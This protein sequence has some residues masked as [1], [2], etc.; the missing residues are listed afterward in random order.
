MPYTITMLFVLTVFCFSAFGQDELKAPISNLTNHQIDSIL[1]ENSSRNLTVTERMKL[2]SEMFLGMGYNFTCI[3]DGENALLEDYPLVNFNQTNCMSYCEHVLALSISDSWD[4][5]FNNLQ[6]IRYS[7]GFIGMRTR[8]HYTMADW[9]PENSWLLDD[10]SANVGGGYTRSV[11]RTISHQEFFKGK[12]ITDLRHVKPDMEVTV[13]YVP[14]EN[15]PQVH[16]NIRSGDVMAILYRDKNDIFSAHMMMAFRIGGDL[17]IRESTTLG[18]T[19]FD[20]PFSDWISSRNGKNRY[21]GIS[22]MRV[23]EG[24]DLPGRVI[25]PWEIQA[26]KESR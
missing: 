19:T 5:F 15:L 2:Y 18:M 25:L 16:K 10:V 17:V 13:D 7:G 4:N 9:L 20:T 24:L 21:I 1:T 26:L 11:T 8:N 6:Q 12:G 3:G 23:R 14:W 22:F